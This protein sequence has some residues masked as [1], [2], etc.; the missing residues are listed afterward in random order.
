MAVLRDSNAPCICFRSSSSSCR[1]DFDWI[2]RF[3]CTRKKTPKTNSIFQNLES[4]TPNISIICRDIRVTPSIWCTKIF[5]R[6]SDPT[7]P[8]Y[9]L[10]T[11][12]SHPKGTISWSAPPAERPM[13]LLPRRVRCR[14]A[15]T[16]SHEGDSLE[17]ELGHENWARSS[18]SH[19]FCEGIWTWIPMNMFE[20]KKQVHSLIIFTRGTCDSLLWPWSWSPASEWQLRPQMVDEFFK[21]VS[22]SLKIPGSRNP[23]RYLR[24][25]TKD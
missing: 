20:N 22:Q 6:I 1:W 25:P 16:T 8:R 7:P 23:W 14:T 13:A 19:S 12:S 5:S 15:L 4:P 9:H 11:R 24:C 3:R 17:R 10:I 21:S 18:P 2:S